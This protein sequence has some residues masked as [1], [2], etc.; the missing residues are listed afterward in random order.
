MLTGHK[1]DDPALREAFDDYMRATGFGRAQR[2]Y[3][4]A[5]LFYWEHRSGMWLNAHLTESDIAFD[6]FILVNSRRVYR[7]LLS[8]PLRDRINGTV[9]LELIRRAWPEVLDVPVNGEPLS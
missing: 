8:A 5:D 7:L 2:R 4:P 6:T 1:S 9:F 3:D